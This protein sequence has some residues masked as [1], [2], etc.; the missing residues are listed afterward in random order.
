MAQIKVKQISDFIAASNSLTT[1]AIS[2]V[3]ASVN[4]IETVLTGV[5]TGAT[6]TAIQASV[7]SLEG[8][9]S[10]QQQL[11]QSILSRQL[12]VH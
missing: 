2:P 4:S 6:V 12:M 11:T 5:A 9:A 10:A 7:D 1:I 8:V 3:E